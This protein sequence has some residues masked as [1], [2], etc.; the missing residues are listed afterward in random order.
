MEEN[1]KVTV[2]YD[3]ECPFCTNFVMVANLRKSYEFLC[4]INARQ[5]E[6][7][8]VKFVRSRG[9]DLNKGMVVMLADKVLY[10]SD[11]ANFI[12]I[13][14]KEGLLGNIYRLLLRNKKLAK[15][16]YPILTRLRRI[17]FRLVGKELIR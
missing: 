8:T 5:T 2:I 14:C 9:F 6:N 7:E 4:L 13:H 15:W 1:N 17:F 10:G 12:A 11:A 3:G 16:I